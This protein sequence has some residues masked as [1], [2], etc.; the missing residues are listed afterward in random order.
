MDHYDG[1]VQCVDVCDRPSR[2]PGRG[3]CRHDTSAAGAMGAIGRFVFGN[4]LMV[5]RE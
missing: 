3:G 5:V 2:L 4:F 1:E